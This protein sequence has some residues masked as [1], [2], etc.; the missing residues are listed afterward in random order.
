MSPFFSNKRLI[1]LLVSLI[2]LVALIG[3]SM[4]DRERSFWP[5]QFIKDTVGWFQSVLY[6]P[7]HMAAGFFE[8]IEDI[9][10][11]Y[12]QNQVLKSHLDDYAE[13]AEKVKRLEER[14]KELQK[15]LG[16]LDDPDLAE[17]TVRQA[18]VIA[19]SP[20]SWNQ[21][22]TINKG[23]QDGVKPDMAVITAEGLI[24]KI[25][26][27]NPFSSTVQLVSDLDRTNFIAA[28]IRGKDGAKDVKGMI[29]GYH[30]EKQALLFKLI[31]YDAQLK[32]G[33]TVV[34]SGLGGV[35]PEGLII[36]KVQEVS[37]DQQG[38]TKTAYV[39]PAA[40][41]YDI[42]HVMIVDRKALSPKN[43]DRGEGAES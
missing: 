7:A 13:L 23:S 42:Y 26:A 22:I 1:V 15:T 33:Q 8:N 43:K 38:L 35:I 40:N 29:A 21:Q 41:L 12:H 14:N 3:Y 24:G 32:K 17:Y 37:P 19:R 10:E 28:V 27:V 30:P 5:E 6:K 31:P 36:G 9:R 11:V 2:I 39:K 34:T 20:D 16:K 18:H 4:R 25:D